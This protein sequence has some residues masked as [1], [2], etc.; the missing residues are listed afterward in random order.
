MKFSLNRTAPQA[1]TNDDIE[2]ALNT[3]GQLVYYGEGVP[4]FTPTDLAG[5]TARALFIRTDGGASTTLY[6]YT[7]AG[8]TAK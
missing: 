8:W 4:T 3:I 1:R 2:R 7:G 6:V 5:N